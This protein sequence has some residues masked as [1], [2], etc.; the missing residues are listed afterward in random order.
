MDQLIRDLAA[1]ESDQEFGRK[2]IPTDLFIFVEILLKSVFPEFLAT[3]Q[4][5]GAFIILQPIVV[6]FEHAQIAL[7]PIRSRKHLDK[8]HENEAQPYHAHARQFPRR[9]PKA[10][11]P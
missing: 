9:S 6:I 2:I 7:R 5:Y 10:S 11:S 1:A 3:I 4:S 8:R